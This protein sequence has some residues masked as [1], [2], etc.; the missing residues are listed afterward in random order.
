MLSGRPVHEASTVNAQ[1]SHGSQAGVHRRAGV[2]LGSVA[3]RSS[4][5]I[6]ITF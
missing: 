6:A 2:E 1:P 5:V 3:R 4:A